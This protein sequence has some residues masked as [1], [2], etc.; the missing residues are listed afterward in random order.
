MINKITIMVLCYGD[1][2]NLAERCLSSIINNFDKNKYILRVGLN[3]VC[4]QTRNYVQSLK[5]VDDIFISKKNIHK[6]GMWRRMFKDIQTEWIMWF[7]D[8]SHV[9]DANALEQRLDLINKV[10]FDIAGHV[11]FLYDD[12]QE[13]FR[14]FKDYIKSQ[15]WYTN[16]P[17]PCG[18]LK[19][20]EHFNI[21]GNEKR[22]FFLT[23]GN[24][25][26]R[27]SAI[28]KFDYPPLNIA[29]NFVD[30]DIINN[31]GDDILICEILRQNNYKL[32]DIGELGIRINDG[33][34]RGMNDLSDSKEFIK[35]LN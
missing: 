14:Q 1:H 8:D 7:D 6:V 4:D 16:K 2:F 25:L 33:S 11:Y 15:D 29:K 20:E 35:N 19:Y 17:I 13:K 9:V 23:G 5:E 28:K 26:I 21:D 34:R 3:K 12:G 24:W 32:L 27:K 30:K 31:E 18:V 10:E 22:W